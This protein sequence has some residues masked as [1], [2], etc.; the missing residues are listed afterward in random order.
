MPL[1]RCASA[2]AGARRRSPSRRLLS[3]DAARQHSMSATRARAQVD[4]LAPRSFPSTSAATMPRLPQVAGSPRRRRDRGRRR[5]RWRCRRWWRRL[6]RRGRGLL[7]VLLV[8]RL[9]GSSCRRCCAAGLSLSPVLLLLPI[10]LPLLLRRRRIRTIARRQRIPR[11]R[12]RRIWPDLVGVGPAACWPHAGGGAESL[13]R[14]LRM[15][16]LGLGLRGE[17]GPAHAS[18]PARAPTLK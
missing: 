18:P 14:A 11:R 16:A 10:R 12:N 8:G 17:A 5:R 1:T 4:N 9:C 2:A 13:A 3:A 6:H 15:L 7:R